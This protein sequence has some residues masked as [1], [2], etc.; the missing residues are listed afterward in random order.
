M[1]QNYPFEITLDAGKCS[2]RD[3]LAINPVPDKLDPFTEALIGGVDPMSAHQALTLA[4]PILSFLG[5]HAR[6]LY[7]DGTLRWISGQSWQMG[8]SGCGKSLVLRALEELFLSREIREK[9]ENARKAAAYTM[10]SET[11]RRGIPVPQEKVRLFDSIPTALALLQQ[12]QINDGEAIYIS[13]SECGEFAKKI[14]NP[15]YA[16]V[17]DMMKKSYDGTGAPFLHKTAD[18]TYFVPSMR[19]CCNV[20]GT[21][22]PMF[23]IFRRCDA[24]GTLSRASLT[25]LGER[26]NDPSEGAYKAP[27]WSLEQ[28]RLMWTAA[29]RLRE[30]DNRY[31]ECETDVEN[32][33]AEVEDGISVAEQDDR[34]MEERRSR[35]LCVPEIVALGNE[36]K[37]HLASY[38][39]EIIDDCCSRADERAM[40]LAYLLYIANDESA[41]VL[42]D[43]ISTVRWWVKISIDCAYAVQ[44]AINSGTHSYKEIVRSNYKAQGINRVQQEVDIARDEAFREYETMYEGEEKSIADFQ[45]IPI[46]RALC[47]RT[48]RRLVQDRGYKSVKRG[49]YIVHSPLPPRLEAA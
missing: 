29:E 6:V 40:G 12:A 42:G 31:R 10:L 26:K 33:P 41:D 43:I 47:P 4:F 9:T 46:L 22:D 35:A 44:L 30:F 45:Q 38:G 17:L 27:C 32:N 23:R 7:S 39:T 16:L 21:I 14:A 37:A 36:I 19:L 24:D 1:T 34:L 18:K 3:I 20:G 13:C 11:E 49:V 8:G 48:V 28:K 25:I 5:Q 2:V 15:Y